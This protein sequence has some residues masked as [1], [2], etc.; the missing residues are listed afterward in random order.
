MKTPVTDAMLSSGSSSI[1]SRVDASDELRPPFQESDHVRDQFGSPVTELTYSPVS[2]SAT[3]V[4]VAMGS[5]YWR[6]A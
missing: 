2:G 6:M 1:L 3:A 5:S 4:T